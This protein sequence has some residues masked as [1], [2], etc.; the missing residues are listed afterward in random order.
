MAVEQSFIP[1]GETGE[2]LDSV[3][4]DT[5]AGTDLHRETVV[6][7]DPE[8]PDGLGRVLNAEPTSD[9]YAAAVRAVG[10]NAKLDSLIAKPAQ[11]DALTDAQLRA[12]PLVVDTGITQ[13]TTPGDTQ[14]VKDAATSGT[15]G[16][17]AG[18]TGVAIVP[19]GGR[20]LQVSA[21]AG[22]STAATFTI[23]GGAT[24]T[25][26]P[27]RDFTFEPKGNLVAPTLEFTNTTSYVVEYV[28]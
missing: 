26:P 19:T 1:I 23:N 2:K 17:L 22:D 18:T 3:R 9:V 8:N 7:A 21:A 13:P 5:P 4:V 27:Y 24:V 20:V 16:Y 14:P 15:W 6:A 12:T 11:L 10:V 25:V 28:T